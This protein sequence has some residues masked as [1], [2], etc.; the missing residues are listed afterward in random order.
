MAKIWLADTAAGGLE[1]PARVF[2]GGRP[3]LLDARMDASVAQVD[4]GGFSI[5][6]AFVLILSSGQTLC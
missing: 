3:V 5:F 2:A 4:V 6:N 1:S